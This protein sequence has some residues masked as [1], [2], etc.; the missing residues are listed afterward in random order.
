[1][2]MRV[3]R[4]QKLGIPKESR[5]AFV[6]MHDGKLLT[7]DLTKKMLGFVGFRN[8]AVHNYKKLDLDIVEVI[9]KKHLSNFTHL[10]KICL[11]IKEKI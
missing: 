6:L 10:A 3:C 11:Q 7:D 1:M 2:G 4:M 9:I 5:E 8:T